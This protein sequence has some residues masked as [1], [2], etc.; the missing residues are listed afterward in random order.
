MHDHGFNNVSTYG[1]LLRLM[2]EEKIPV[3]LVPKDPLSNN[4]HFYVLNGI[5]TEPRN[6]DETWFGNYE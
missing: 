5:A 2:K 1:N 6:W 4:H 3:K